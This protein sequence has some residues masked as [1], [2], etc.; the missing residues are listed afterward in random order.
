MRLG[1]VTWISVALFSFHSYRHERRNINNQLT[2][3]DVIEGISQIACLSILL[4]AFTVPRKCRARNDL[5]VLDVKS[6]E[7]IVSQPSKQLVR[8]QSILP[9]AACLL[10]SP[11]LP[12]LLRLLPFAPPQLLTY[13]NKNLVSN[14]S[15]FDVLLLCDDDAENEEGSDRGPENNFIK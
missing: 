9:S 10:T 14:H 1:A 6:S 7:A 15:V 12:L 13:L 5:K 3:S 2:E 11:L 4:D 8:S